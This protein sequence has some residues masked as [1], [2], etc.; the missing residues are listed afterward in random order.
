MRICLFEQRPETLTPLSLTRP[1]FDLLC[2][3]TSLADKQR[4]HFGPADW[5]MLVRP[6]LAN[7]QRLRQPAVPC[8]DADWLKRDSL[9]LVNGRWLPP[10]KTA[11]AASDPHVAVV[12]GEI[13]YVVVPAEQ[14]RRLTFDNLPFLLA[15]WRTTLPQK[16]AGGHLI[17]YPWQLVQHNGDAIARDFAAQCSPGTGAD[18]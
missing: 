10:L 9:V 13:A 1:V 15:N 12:D 11:Q 8:N 17:D 3:I 18:R 16:N 4:R 7:L 6:A 5:G 14:A 2:G